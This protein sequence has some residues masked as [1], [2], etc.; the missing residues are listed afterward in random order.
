MHPFL[1]VGHNESTC[2]PNSQI[3]QNGLQI[4]GTAVTA[5]YVVEAPRKQQRKKWMWANFS[6]KNLKSKKMEF[7]P[8]P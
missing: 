7:G 5:V 1:I 2:S 4:Q 3:L 6:Q 8:K